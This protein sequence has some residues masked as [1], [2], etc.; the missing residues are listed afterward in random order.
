MIGIYIVGAQPQ[1]EPK[2]PRL[3]ASVPEALRGSH[4]HDYTELNLDRAILLLA[5]PMVLEMSM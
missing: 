4:Y 5:I 1:P 2:A 3:W